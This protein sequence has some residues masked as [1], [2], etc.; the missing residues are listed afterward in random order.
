MIDDLLDVADVPDI[1]FN[2]FSLM[3]AHKQGA[4]F[5][6]EDEGLRISFFRWKVEV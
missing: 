6:A 5:T 4:R 3:A 1:T 2:L